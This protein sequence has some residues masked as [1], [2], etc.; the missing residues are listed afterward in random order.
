MPNRATILT[1]ETALP[2]HS[3]SAAETAELL[4]RAFS[5]DPRGA[6]A[7]RAVIE[8]SSIR[9][10]FLVAPPEHLI[11]PR[12]LDQ[13]SC[14]YKRHAIALSQRAA[15]SALT[16]AGLGVTDIDLILT[17]SCTGLMIPSLD[18][19]LINLMQFRP[20]IKRLPI[21]ELGCAAGA[22]AL[23]R[24]AEYLAAFPHHHVLLIAVELTSLTFQPD[25][26][27]QANL[28]SCCLFGDGA[29]A[30]VLTGAD[31]PSL[32]IVDS[33]SHLV[34]GSTAAMGFDLRSTGLRVTLS[35][36]VPQTVR[37]EIG[38][39]VD[40]LL[41]ANQL[42]RSDLQFFAMHPGGQKLLQSIEDELALTATDTRASWSVLAQY[43]NISGATVLFVLK[44]L[45]A[46]PA[47]EPNSFG[48]MGAFGPGFSI[49]L[50]LLQ[51][52]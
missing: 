40:R 24:A 41:N 1:V 11:T 10:R 23:A 5:L 34:P 26:R 25:D 6:A 15:E 44:E 27:S 52:I 37:Q 20:D 38:P 7:V 19:H 17:V 35:K 31:Q 3:I 8:H 42:S 9:K 45:L 50:S 2:A 43:G 22:A 46:G 47:P 18:A 13:I 33:R 51:W 48:L 32:Q 28:I 30:A 29:A 49:E 4:P 14:E 21:T 39:A 12:P 16:R 36:D